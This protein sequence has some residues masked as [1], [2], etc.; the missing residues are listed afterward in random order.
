MSVGKRLCGAAGRR[1]F[2]GHSCR[3]AGSSFF[4]VSQQ[5]MVT[6]QIAGICAM[7]LKSHSPIRTPTR[8]EH[9]SFVKRASS[10]RPAESS[11]SVDNKGMIVDREAKIEKL[12]AFVSEAVA[13]M[14]TLKQE[15]SLTPGVPCFDIVKN[16]AFRLLA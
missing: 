15:M 11:A 12:T 16:V 2:G 7:G 6:Q 4:W 1:R 8:L 9:V 14:E 5:G 3:V 10:A 13:D